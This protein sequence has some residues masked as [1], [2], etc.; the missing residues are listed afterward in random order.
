MIQI[1]TVGSLLLFMVFPAQAF[2]LCVRMPDAQRSR[3]I[4]GIA[5]SHGWTPT[6]EDQNCGDRPGGCMNRI[7]PNPISKPQFVHQLIRTF[8]HKTVVE[9]ETLQAAQAAGL[10]ARQKAEREIEITDAP[11]AATS[12][13]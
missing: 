12:T 2:D 6:I 4:D 10:A 5:L 13:P 1:L 3:V 9:W 7:I 8:V 11:S